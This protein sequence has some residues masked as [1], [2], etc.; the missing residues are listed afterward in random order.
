MLATGDFSSYGISH[1]VVLALL[2]AAAWWLVRRGRRSRGSAAA[3]RLSVAFAL[4]F[5]LPTLPLQIWFQLP[6]RFSLG[7]SLP[8]QLCDLAW[9]TAVYA[10]FTRRRWAIALTYYWGLTLSTQAVLTPDLGAG[11]PDPA[12]ILYWAMHGL[13]VVAAIYL[14]WG[15]GLPPD[16][17]S[18]RIA[19]AATALWAAVVFAFNSIADVN[20]GFLNA[21]PDSASILDLFGPWPW[22]VLVEIVLVATIWALITWPWVAR[23]TSSGGGR[24]DRRHRIGGA[25]A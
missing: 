15:L 8:I 18:Y 22:Y 11:F 2:I 4:I 5:L 23:S 6:D 25:G 21:K 7:L 12:F 24:G 10:L 9:L 14:T 1:Q 20:Y 13:T 16:W 3:D 17:R 19:V